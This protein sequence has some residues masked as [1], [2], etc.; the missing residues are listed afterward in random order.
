[1]ALNRIQSRDTA[2]HGHREGADGAPPRYEEVVHAG[3]AP[4]V[5]R[6]NDEEDSVVADGKTPL[7]EIPFEEVSNVGSQSSGS[8]SRSFAEVHHDGLGDTRGHTNI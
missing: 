5:L 4:V 8:A 6:T 3:I 7:S 2:Q 1:M